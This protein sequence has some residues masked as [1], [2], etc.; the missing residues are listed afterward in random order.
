MAFGNVFNLT[1]R[2]AIRKGQRYQ[3]T[4]RYPG[5]IVT[6]IAGLAGQIKTRAGGL[7]IAAW[8]FDTPIYN[9]AQEKTEITAFLP[10]EVTSGIPAGVVSGAYDLEMTIQGFG[11]IRLVQGKVELSEEITE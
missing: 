4:M 1:G 3:M 10:W 5:N 8:S 2:Y 9:V 11:P 7:L 6:A